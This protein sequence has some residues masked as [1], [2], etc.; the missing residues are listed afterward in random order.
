MK[1]YSN[2][3]SAGHTLTPFE[4]TDDIK[5]VYFSNQIAS[6]GSYLFYF[7]QGI[8]AIEIPDSVKTI[9]NNAFY[10]C[11]NIE[12]L[13]LHEGLVSVGD[14]AFDSTGIKELQLPN[15]IKYIGEDAFSS[16]NLE[17]EL[18]IPSNVEFLGKGFI[19]YT[20]ISILTVDANNRIYHSI[21]NCIIET[22]TKTIV[23]GCKN[24]II[25][26]DGSVECIGE[27]AFNGC[28]F[29]EI[30]IPN[31]ITSIGSYAFSWYTLEKVYIPNSVVQ[32]GRCAFYG[33]KNL[34]IRCES[35][36]QPN[37][38]DD[39]WNKVDAFPDKYANI[40]WG[41]IE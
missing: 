3:T 19:G 36:N 28:A 30:T 9:G 13:V 26:N 31:T 5:E 24:S 22:A 4:K 2:I 39:D 18:I 11:V 41:Y 6:I 10:G 21:G 33:H 35:S 12:I 23:A 29:T 16:T 40:V 15:S 37:D 8:T 20:N 38:W 25:P 1:N 17:G 14:E 34:I 27:S 32:I 7:C